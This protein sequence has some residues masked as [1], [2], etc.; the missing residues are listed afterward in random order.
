MRGG[1]SHHLHRAAIATA[2]NLILGQG[3]GHILVV[4][5]RQIALT[6]TQIV[7]GGQ[8]H[9]LLQHRH[10]TGIEAAVEGGDTVAEHGTCGVV[11]RIGP[12]GGSPSPNGIYWNPHVIFLQVDDVGEGVGRR[13]HLPAKFDLLRRL[14]HGDAI[15]V[16]DGGRGHIGEA[17]AL[18]PRH[19]ATARSVGKFHAIADD[20]V[21]HVDGVAIHQ[22]LHLS[23]LIPTS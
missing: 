1:L 12:L 18:R 19:I 6:A 13:R 20:G 15:Q 4:G 10:R 16:G 3:A 17:I 7:A 23:P 14:I 11:L 5:P 22:A 2:I 8:L 21:A 9:T